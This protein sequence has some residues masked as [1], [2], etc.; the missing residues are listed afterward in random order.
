MNQSIDRIALLHGRD[1]VL[2]LYD[3]LFGRE[4]VRKG[5]AELLDCLAYLRRY[6]LAKLYFGRLN[7]NKIHIKLNILTDH[8]DK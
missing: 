8:I 4:N 5:T 3:L 1:S 2:V 6:S 7:A